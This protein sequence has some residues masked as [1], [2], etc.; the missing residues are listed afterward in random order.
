MLFSGHEKRSFLVLFKTNSVYISM[1]E[2]SDF[3]LELN[4]QICKT[5]L[6]LVDEE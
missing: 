2:D 4:S 1:K 3:R 6:D 5:T